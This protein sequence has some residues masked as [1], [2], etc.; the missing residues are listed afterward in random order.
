MVDDHRKRVVPKRSSAAVV[1][2]SKPLYVL[3]DFNYLEIYPTFNHIF[4]VMYTKAEH[5]AIQDIPNIMR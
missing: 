5:Q 2:P 1:A 3:P 4:S